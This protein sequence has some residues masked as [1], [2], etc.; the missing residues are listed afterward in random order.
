MLT[1]STL[2]VIMGTGHPY[3]TDNNQPNGAAGSD[4]VWEALVAKTLPVAD[5]DRNGIADDDWTLIDAK[6]QF[7]DL[8][9][10]TTPPKRLLGIPRVS[11]T[12][13]WYR[14]DERGYGPALYRDDPPGKVP[15]NA[16]VPT[17]AT[18][19]RGALNVL[20]QNPKG[21]FVMIE[22]GA[23]DWAC[24]NHHYGRLIEETQD[25]DRAVEA[26]VDWV[27]QNSNWEE[28][29]LVVTA[30]HENGHIWGPGSSPSFGPLVNN[31]AGQMPEFYYYGTYH[32]NALVPVYLKCS[33]A[34][35]YLFLPR[36]SR[37]DPRR[38]PYLDNT[39][40]GQLFIG[41]ITGALGR[42]CSPLING[43]LRRKENAGWMFTGERQRRAAFGEGG[44]L[45]FRVG[46]VGDLVYK[47]KDCRLQ[48]R[49]FFFWSEKPRVAPEPSSV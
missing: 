1:T 26:V 48:F 35:A 8:A 31:G 32:T 40:L 15:F 38:G 33:P 47:D 2:D 17:L 11:Q 42:A 27:N 25:F 6:T 44:P 36:A 3:Y 43:L 45:S 9:T 13:Q 10:T 19:A 23:I 4:W 12:L 20:H 18:M 34:V 22:G 5:A 24:H 39:D 46:A 30:D 14:T 7:E 29:M 21:F 16:G 49:R 28:T 37:I 41:L